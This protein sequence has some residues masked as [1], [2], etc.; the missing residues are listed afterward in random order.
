VNP[1]QKLTCEAQLYKIS[2]LRK[3]LKV[4][5]QRKDFAVKTALCVVRSADLVAYEDLKVRNMV[6]TRKLAKSISDVAWTQFRH[7]IE[8]FGKVYGVATVA[9]PPH[10]TSQNCSSCGHIVKKTL[11][12]RTHV[13]PHC[14]HTQDRDHNAAINILADAL[15]TVGHTGSKVCEENDLC[16]SEETHKNKSARNTRKGKKQKAPSAK[17]ESHAVT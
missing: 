5:R 3:H 7:W 16:L 17:G 1:D 12:C 4:S 6:K 8:Y 10:Y 2:L 15:R 13:C 14:G 9:V 11:S